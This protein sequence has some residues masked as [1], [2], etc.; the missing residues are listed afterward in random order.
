MYGEDLIID[1]F[2]RKKRKGFYVDVG[3]YHPLDGNNT[4][5]LYK[6]GWSGMNIDVNA[7]SIELFNQAR[8][9][10]HNIN[11]AVSNK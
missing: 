4:C 7:L 10:D 5:L 9:D 11:V 8:K 6:K 1:K 3:C 2:F